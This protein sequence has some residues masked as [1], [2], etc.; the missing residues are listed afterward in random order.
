MERHERRAAFSAFIW[1]IVVMSIAGGLI[2]WQSDAV[3][4][5]PNNQSTTDTSD[6]TQYQQA[7]DDA[8]NRLTEASQRITTLEQQV[9]QAN[10]TGQTAQSV[11]QAVAD[12]SANT[13]TGGVDAAAAI[14]IAKQVA[15]KLKPIQDPELVDL[16]GKTVWSIVYTPGTVYVSQTD[17]QIVLVQR[18]NETRGV[19]G[20]DNDG[21]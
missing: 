14:E 19:T 10:Q 3:H 4:A 6:I 11:P 9:A 5:V 17:G 21:N 20:D 7:L 18:N 13:P 12:T 2:L 16:E 8:N 15:G 1:T